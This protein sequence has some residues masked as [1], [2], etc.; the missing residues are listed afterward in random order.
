MTLTWPYWQQ[1]S[2]DF[3]IRAVTCGG[4]CL[5]DIL[6]VCELTIF[7]SNMK[8][9]KYSSNQIWEFVTTLA[10]STT[11]PN[12]YTKVLFWMSV[13]KWCINEGMLFVHVICAFVLSLPSYEIEHVS[14]SSHKIIIIAILVINVSTMIFMTYL[15]MTHNSNYT[16]FSVY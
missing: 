3:V 4:L 14:T 7:A 6:L 2:Y 9:R 16:Q 15:L 13:V 5:R 12:K 10:K 11:S 8:I 1:V